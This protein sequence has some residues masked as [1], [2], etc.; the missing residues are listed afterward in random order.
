MRI[1]VR[2]IQII[3]GILFIISGLVKANDPMGLA[4]KME[5]FF[6]IWNTELA[7]GG[8]FARS[9]L[10]GFFEFLH[11]QA[12]ALSIAMITLEIVA[13]VALLVG[14]KPRSVL[15]LLLVLIIFFTFLTGYAF[16]SK[17]PDGSPKFTN[18]GCFGDCLPIPPLASFLKDLALLVMIGFLL[19]ARKYILPI[20]SAKF[21]NT[22]LASSL[23]LSLLL[24]WYVLT[25]LPLKDCL[26][27]KK[28]NNLAEQTKP[29]KGSKP[30]I[31]E[32]RLVYKNKS[33]GAV[34]EMSQEEFN[35][36]NI[37]EDANWEWSET[38][39][40][41]VQKGADPAI[42]GFSLVSLRD[43][44]ATDSLTAVLELPGYS[45]LYFVNDEE[46]PEE[47]INGALLKSAEER[48]VPVFF[49][50]SNPG[51]FKNLLTE[52]P[53]LRVFKTDGTVF[54]MA[55]RANPTIYLVQKG[56]VVN[57]WSLANVKDATRTIN[58][59]KQ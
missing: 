28:A 50:T 16:L 18:C 37:W 21:R 8:F 1:T 32:S 30:S 11:G 10:I 59:I 54:K 31:Y 4:Y 40:K 53:G 5:E 20:G 43:S 39:T 47:K 12:V 2:T 51:A 3:V 9:A 52:N 44:S 36:S 38:K 49:V 15:F 46:N 26:P 13:G 22:I 48:N 55:A 29:P 6:E 24:Q 35:Q 17:N 33:T 23:V 58:E 41:M 27:F 56:L 45:V 57:K 34:R 19:A 14:W 25:Y 7:S 42:N